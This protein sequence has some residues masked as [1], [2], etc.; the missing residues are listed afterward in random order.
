MGRSPRSNEVLILKLDSARDYSNPAVAAI[1][2]FSGRPAA[3]APGRAAA[4]AAA[5]YDRATT[6]VRS[7][8]SSP[9][10]AR[11]PSGRWRQRIDSAWAA[12]PVLAVGPQRP[13]A[14]PGEPRAPRL[15]GLVQGGHVHGPLLP[16][17]RGLGQQLGTD[18]PQ[19][20]ADRAAH[21]GQRQRLLLAACAGSPR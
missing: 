18:P 15:D 5:Q 2:L 6:A 17:G 8:S 3:S 20:L 13:H 21:A 1:P 4:V 12:E 14:D 16:G 9:G 7:A 10:S 11:L 19:D